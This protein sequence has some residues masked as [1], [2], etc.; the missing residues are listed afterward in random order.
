MRKLLVSLASVVLGLASANAQTLDECDLPLQIGFDDGTAETSFKIRAPS[1]SGDFFNVDFDRVAANQCIIA[2]CAATNLTGPGGAID[3]LGIYPDNLAVDPTGTT[4]DLSNPITEITNPTGVPTGF[5]TGFVAYDIPDVTLGSTPVH[6]GMTFPAGD[7]SLWLCTDTNGAIAGRSY[8]TTNSYATPAIPF[9]VNWMLRLGSAPAAGTFLVN[10]QA[11]AK[12]SEGDQ[13][14]ISFWGNKGKTGERA[15]IAVQVGAN[16]VTLPFVLPTG[17]NNSGIPNLLT[18]KGTVPMIGL[19][20]PLNLTLFAFWLDTCTG[21]IRVSTS[22]ALTICPPPNPDLCFGRKDDGVL[23]G[24]IWKV[25]NPAGSL[26][27][28]NVKHDAAGTTAVNNLTGVDIASWDFCGSSQTW[29]EVGIYDSNT[30]LDP[31]GGTPGTSLT[32]DPTPTFAANAADWG[33]PATFYD[34]G[35]IAA[36]TTTIYHAVAMWPSGDSCIWLGSDTDAID[37]D[38]AGG[39]EDCSVLP[40][41]T[42][43]FTLDGYNTPGVPFSTANWMMRI[44]WN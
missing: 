14:V 36:N 42:S 18:L 3:R 19:T 37:D 28:F 12:V 9:S 41:T 35:D 16:T 40:N 5:C 26:D 1:A 21:R 15:L 8:F 33:C 6:M 17:L 34:V 24:N 2:L 27:F 13:V 43:F 38:P 4:P 7:S 10:G 44:T 23:D 22:A 32:N 25:Q 11:A 31:S 30:T 20:N 29:G 39:K